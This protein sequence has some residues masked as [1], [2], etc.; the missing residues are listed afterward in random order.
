[1]KQKIYAIFHYLLISCIVAWISPLTLE[2]SETGY[3]TVT[4]Y[5]SP[6]PNQEYYLTGDYEREKRLNGQ[7]IAGASGKKVFSGMLAGPAS[8]PFGTKIELEWVGIW[9]IEDRGG[10]IVPAWQRGNNHDRIDIWVGY[11]DEWLRRALYWGKRTIKW[12]I[13][14]RNSQVNLD[15]QSLSAPLWVTWNIVSQRN[16]PWVM[17]QSNSLSKTIAAT[18]QNITIQNT[19]QEPELFQTWLGKND[20]G[21]L[22]EELQDILVELWYLANEDLSK[23]YDSKIIEAV[24]NLQL[25]YNIVTSSLSP[26]AGYFGP[27]TREV[28][29]KLYK[30]HLE[31]LE[32]EKRY[33]AMIDELLEQARDQAQERVDTF[34]NP[35]FGDISAQVRNLQIL[36]RE[37]WYFDRSD[38]A[39]F[40]NQ[41]RDAIIGLQLQKEVI[42]SRD[43]TWAWILGP[44]TRDVITEELTRIYFQR[45]LEEHEIY[46]DFISRKS[47]ESI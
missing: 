43:E 41:T 22:V 27:R 30:E 34:W 20:T 31:K 38:T 8:Y 33:H 4:A 12:N 3:F 40:W 11:G 23:T 35:Q 36:L 2:A 5:Y 44:V 42:A 1:M 25:E 21:K 14:D 18:T 13:I 15:I 6:L 39:I 17:F 32:E 9:V 37:L 47:R 10:A 46:E 28:T 26:G 16:A 19:Q 45:I 29:Q 7:G 24:Y